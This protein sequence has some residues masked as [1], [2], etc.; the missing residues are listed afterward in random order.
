MQNDF[1]V[2]HRRNSI[3]SNVTKTTSHNSNV[4]GSY[5]TT[6]CSLELRRDVCFSID[7]RGLWLHCLLKTREIPLEVTL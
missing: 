7:V 5:M 3:M 1:V 2:S 6:N 4:M